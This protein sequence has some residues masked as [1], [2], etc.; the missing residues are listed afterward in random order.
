MPVSMVRG[1]LFEQVILFVL[2]RVN[3]NIFIKQVNLLYIFIFSS[4]VLNNHHH[5]KTSWKIQKECK[6][7][8]QKL[9]K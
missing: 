3:S 1:L 5:L 7:N 2:E 6:Y 4:E 9:Q 8:E